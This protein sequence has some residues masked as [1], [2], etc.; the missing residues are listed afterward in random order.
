[1]ETEDTKLAPTR[2]GSRATVS[3]QPVR[4]PPLVAAAPSPAVHQNPNP[5]LIVECTRHRRHYSV[6]WRDGGA[7]A[8]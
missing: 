1:M 6:A 3:S 5:N 8:A 4:E 7:A 2:D